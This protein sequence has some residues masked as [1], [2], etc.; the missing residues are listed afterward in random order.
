[1]Q[2]RVNV[3]SWIYC[4]AHGLLRLP[5]LMGLMPM[6]DGDNGSESHNVMLTTNTYIPVPVHAPRTAVMAL[7][8]VAVTTLC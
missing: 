6:D 8:A 5:L 3:V 7:V 1:M 2:Q 4:P